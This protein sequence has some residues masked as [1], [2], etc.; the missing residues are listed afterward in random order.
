[1]AATIGCALC[2][3]CHMYETRR[4]HYCSDALKA[5]ESANPELVVE[6]IDTHVLVTIEH[7]GRD[8]ATIRIPRSEAD[9][10]VESLSRFILNEIERTTEEL[11]I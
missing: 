7:Y 8:A 9:Q 2:L 10:F 5:E 4:L 3:W 1:M 6:V 11:A